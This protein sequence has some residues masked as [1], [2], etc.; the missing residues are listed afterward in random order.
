MCHA[1]GQNHL[2]L[3]QGDGVHNGG[4]DL[5][6]HHRIVGLDQA[7]LWA[8]LDGDIA[9]QL[10]VIQ[11][12]FKAVALVGQVAGGLGIFRQAGCF[13]LGFSGGQV[14][15]PHL[16]QLFAAGQD[17]HAQ[18]LEIDKV[19]LVH[20]VQHGNVFHQGYL[21]VLQ[22]GLDAFHVHISFVVFHFQGFQLVGLFLEKAQEA[23]LIFCGGVKAFQLADQLGDEFAGLTHILGAHAGKRT[24]RKI[25]QL[26]LAGGAVL[27]NHLGVGQ[28]D[29]FSKI[30]H[31]LLLFGAQRGILHGN[32]GSLFGFLHHLGIRFGIQG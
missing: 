26:F 5:F 1:Q 14:V 17:I 32:G 2:V 8:H 12:L 3:P 6:S 31:H 11:L 9:G 4:L 15:L 20:L 30:L 25:T 19:Q 16:L 7:D 21:V 29:L 13:G 18:L 27:Q 24:V 23:F 22:L 28:V 10:Q